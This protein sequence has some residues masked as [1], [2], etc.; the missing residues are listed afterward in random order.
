MAITISSLSYQLLV[1]SS[2][3]EEGL[4][5]SRKEINQAK[6]AMRGLETPME[7]YQRDLKQ[8]E[9]LLKFGAQ[10]QE[11]YNRKLE[12][13]KKRLDDETLAAKKQTQSYKMLQ[14]AKMAAAGV[15]IGAVYA[16]GRQMASDFKELDNLAK[17][18]ARLNIQ[19]ERLVGIQ[20]AVSRASGLSSDQVSKGLE[21]MLRRTSEAAKGLGEAQGALQ[22]LNL[23]ARA[24]VKLAPDEMFRR[25]GAGIAGVKNQSDKLRIA[26]KIF[27]DEQAGIFT[28][29]DKGAGY[30]EEME[31]RAKDL[32]LAV[33]SIDLMQIETTN[34][35]INDLTSSMDG[36]GRSIALELSPKIRQAVYE[37]EKML[38]VWTLIKTAGGSDRG[39]LPIELDDG[40]I[41]YADRTWTQSNM[42]AEALTRGMMQMGKRFASDSGRSGWPAF[43]TLDLPSKEITDKI[44]NSLDTITSV[45]SASYELVGRVGA[46]LG[47]RRSDIERLGEWLFGDKQKS[48]T[49]KRF[50]PMDS[51]AAGSSEAFKFLN[52]TTVRQSEELNVAKENRE[53][54]RGILSVLTEFTQNV[55]TSNAS[56]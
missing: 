50:G 47:N 54:N 33:S 34:D 6:R 46:F 8:A 7:K 20:L 15:A 31:K 42:A 53:A 12:Q 26:T 1:D 9:S 11:L 17:T 24:L 56:G 18:S 52:Q 2:K 3:L 48:I 51:I 39:G 5:A 35:A 10:G 41:V 38:K 44:G 22:E 13:M 49:E 32:G 25:I 4:V 40:R 37:L 27:D 30:L 45:G 19:T 55:S 21:K 28:T 43:P 16:A 36:L 23:D 29:F 14:R